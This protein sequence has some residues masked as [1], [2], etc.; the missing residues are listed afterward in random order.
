MK[1]GAMKAGGSQLTKEQIV[2][3]LMK[4]ADQLFNDRV[5]LRQMTDI[6]A[7]AYGDA[8]GLV[9][10]GMYMNKLIKETKDKAYELDHQ[11]GDLARQMEYLA[12]E[13]KKK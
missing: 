1:A 8:T 11:I 7:D 10:Q 6:L 13:L 3:R 4:S 5:Q 9:T 2:E 12:R